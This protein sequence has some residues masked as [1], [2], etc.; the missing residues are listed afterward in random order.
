[1][2][3]K[4][5]KLVKSML[6]DGISLRK[7]S[8]SIALGVGLGIFPVLG[9]T[10]ILC[11][12][13]AFVLRLNM[14]AIQAVNLM[15]YPLQIILLAPFYGAGS[16]LFSRQGSHLSSGSII[17]V[18]QNDFWGSFI[19]FWDLTLYAILTW[20]IVS[21]LLILMLYSILKPVVGSMTAF[22]GQRG[23]S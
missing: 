15:V 11:T 4:M 13:A 17:E 20:L 18:I 23:F 14:P 2:K 3:T 19:S 7:I 10:T 1:M 16:W 5:F 6:K 21:P 9:M 22:R 8:L 12:F